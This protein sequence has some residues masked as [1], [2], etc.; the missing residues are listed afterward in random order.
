MTKKRRARSEKEVARLRREVE[1]LRAQLAKEE[2]PKPRSKE[3]EKSVEDTKEV[4]IATLK[5]PEKSYNYV[6]RGLKKTAILTIIAFAI[7]AGLYFSQP[8]WQNIF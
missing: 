7:L 4:K 1:I 8:H 2:K 6:R 3:V 5:S